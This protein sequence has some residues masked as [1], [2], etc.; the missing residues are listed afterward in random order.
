MK[1]EKNDHEHHMINNIKIHLN[2]NDLF[3]TKVF[4]ILN[5]S[6]KLHIYVYYNN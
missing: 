5:N 1:P 2:E 4:P 3:K 6:N